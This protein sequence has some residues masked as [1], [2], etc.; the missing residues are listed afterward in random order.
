M[1]TP[2]YKFMKNRGT[3]IYVFPSAA[4]DMSK[5]FQNPNFKVNF[6]K[7]A[8]LN[9]PKQQ[10]GEDQTKGILNFTK[11]PDGERFHN[12]Q[13]DSTVPNLFSEQLIESLRNYVANSDETT[14]IS[15]INT[16]DD[17]YNLSEKETVSEMLFWKWARKLNLIDFEPATNKIDWDKS[18]EEFQNPNKPN[19]ISLDYFNKYLWKE[20]QV[21]SYEVAEIK[22]ISADTIQVRVNSLMK[23]KNGD[24]FKFDGLIEETSGNIEIG[25]SYEVFDVQIFDGAQQT[26][27]KINETGV[28][29]RIFTI[30]EEGLRCQLDYQRLVE[31]IGEITTQSKVETS[32][33]IITEVTANI[34]HHAGK[35]PTILFTIIDNMNYYPNLELPILP[36]QIQD[37]IVGSENIQS[38]IRQN[39]EEY[40]G[41]SYGYYDTDNKTYQTSNGDRLRK[42]GDYYGVLRTN[43]I[44]LDKVDFFEKLTEFNSDNI[45]G[46]KLDFEPD[47]YLKMNLPDVNISNFDEFNT[48][49]FNNEPP[50]DFEFNTIL[51]FYE[52]DDGSGQI[53]S[54]LYG[55]E[56]LNNPNDSGDNDHITTYQKL[57]SNGEQDGLSY[58]YN[59]NISYHSDNDV[60]PMAYDPSTIYNNFGLDLYQNILQSNAQLQE[61]FLEIINN[62]TTIKDDIFKVKS[63]VFSQQQYEEVQKRLENLDALL[64]L[65]STM[66][67]VDSNTNKVE[68]DYS[69]TYPRLRIN[70]TISEFE[71]IRN[72]NCSEILSYNTQT[73][74]PLVI[75]VPNSNKLMLNISNNIV[76]ELEDSL[77]I[78]FNKDLN[79]SQSMDIFIEPNFSNVSNN[80]IM[81]MSYTSLSGE[82]NIEMLNIDLPTDLKEYDPVNPDNSRK[83]L[84][85]YLNKSICEY[86]N[87][88]DN[89][90]FFGKTLIRTN[91]EFFERDDVIWVDNLYMKN[92]NTEEIVDL[93]GAYKLERIRTLAGVKYYQIGL[94]TTDHELVSVIN[95]CSYKGIKIN[96][97]RVTEPLDSTI[98]ER[99]KITKEII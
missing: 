58:I 30:G 9:L 84:N 63:L 23:I 3:T 99:Y 81:E 48:F 40:P 53:Y 60:V 36:E 72:I 27:F 2:L 64:N 15:K 55:I 47:H 14:R 17:F 21:T 39:P 50:I 73:D 66:Q 85:N 5:D 78:R 91:Q 11:D 77:K 42:S 67:I 74:N 76:E 45:D 29:T 20:R 62:F 10:D 75:G 34:P 22:G 28:S 32:K 97:L 33:K 51:W 83:S 31:Y 25:K 4:R 93:S 80:L 98:E 35:T 49:R 71:Q 59:L 16:K 57:V 61:N 41:S 8:L 13:P 94:N 52:I 26:V 56:F 46:L 12:W 95:L 54:N 96:I 69:G 7:F 18:K 70:S 82:E 37:R 44:D 79:F 1:A 6:S 19:N 68:I 88:I 89:Q 90:E 43:N 38:P 65:Y 87:Q 24:Y 92:I 86:S